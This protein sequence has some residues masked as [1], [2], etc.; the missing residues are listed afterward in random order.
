MLMAAR[1]MWAGRICS[2]ARRNRLGVFRDSM[3]GELDNGC[4]AAPRFG[5]GNGVPNMIYVAG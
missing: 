2:R 5:T 4:S 1:S 3:N